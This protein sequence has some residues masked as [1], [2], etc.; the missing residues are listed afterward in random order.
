MISLIT[1]PTWKIKRRKNSAL[2]TEAIN[3]NVVDNVKNV[4]ANRDAATKVTMSTAVK[5][6]LTAIPVKMAS[7]THETVTSALAPRTNTVTEMATTIT[8]AK[9]TTA[10]QN[11]QNQ[12]R[13]NNCN[14]QTRYNTYY[15]EHNRLRN[16]NHH[17]NNEAKTNDRSIAEETYHSSTDHEQDQESLDDNEFYFIKKDHQPPPGLLY[18]NNEEI[19]SEY[20]TDNDNILPLECIL[21]YETDDNSIHPHKH[22]PSLKDPINNNNDDKK[23]STYFTGELLNTKTKT[24]N[25]MPIP[26]QEVNF[27]SEVIIAI[28]CDPQGQGF[29]FL[30]PHQ[31]R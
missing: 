31:L 26:K 17:I 5:A 22:I 28:P 25:V 1:T 16:K 21:E 10:R 27:H 29:I 7:V 18:K 3:S 4:I 14:N 13:Q 2:T 9:K 6:T 11:H 23:H 30:C 24:L 8:T 15:Q 20:E 19:D 12:Y